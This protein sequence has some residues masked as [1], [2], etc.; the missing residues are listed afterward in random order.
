MKFMVSILLGLNLLVQGTVL[1]ASSCFIPNVTIPLSPAAQTDTAPAADLNIS[2]PSAILMEASTGAVVYEKNSH[3]ARH[4]ASVTK[5]MTLLLI[6][7]ALSS[8][9]ISLDDTV[10]V[11]EYAA[12]MGGSQVFL[13]PGETQ[14]VDTMLKCISVASANDACVAMA[15]LISG[16]E[17]AFVQKMNETAASLGMTHTNFVNCCGL[18]ADNHYSCANDIAL[19]SRELTVN[20]PTIFDY[21]KIWQEDIIHHTAR[22]DS[23]F[24][25]SNTNHLIKQYPYAT[26]LKTGF[27]SKAG[28]CLSATATKDSLSLIAVVMGAASSKERIADVK[29]MFDWG[30]A[31]CRVY[32]DENQDVL[33]DILVSRGSQ[34]QLSLQYES[35]FHYLDTQNTSGELEKKLELPDRVEAPIQKGDVIGKAVYTL[36]S[37]NVG[38]VNILAANSIPLLTLKD[39]WVQI[40]SRFFL[41]NSN[42]SSNGEPSVAKNYCSHQYF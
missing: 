11:S 10:T 7:D 40:V 33:P 18:D 32:T 30:F 1:P 16:S 4:P 29:S 5:I 14:S 26:G 3:E 19:M 39:A 22:G 2:A 6:F 21:T 42:H 8:K 15:E 41:N 25:L 27:T 37:E 12:S 35:A 34:S 24:T 38:S 28:F 17:D 13:E 36:N 9:Q 31:N 20:H 23:A